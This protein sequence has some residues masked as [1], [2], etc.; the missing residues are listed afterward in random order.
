MYCRSNVCI[1]ISYSQWLSCSSYESRHVGRGLVEES[2]DI[3]RESWTK[4]SQSRRVEVNMHRHFVAGKIIE[5]SSGFET[6]GIINN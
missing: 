5:F 6:G 3:H 4:E 1:A 2:C